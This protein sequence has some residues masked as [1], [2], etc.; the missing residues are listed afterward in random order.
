MVGDAT[1]DRVEGGRDDV[2]AQHHPGAAAVGIVVDLTRPQG[3]RVPV[4][5]QPQVEATAENGGDRT[6]LGEPAEG[7][8]DEGKNV[9]LQGI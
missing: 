2:H 7:M 1:V 8:W 6:L 4:A 3:C 9:E 5:E